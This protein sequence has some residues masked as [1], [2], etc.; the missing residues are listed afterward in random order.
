ML[1]LIVLVITAS[2]YVYRIPTTNVLLTVEIG[3]LP[4]SR[5]RPPARQTPR[6]RGRPPQLCVCVY[7]CVYVNVYIYIYIYIYIYT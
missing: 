1:C 7:M 2:K 5:R 3:A 4:P 6:P